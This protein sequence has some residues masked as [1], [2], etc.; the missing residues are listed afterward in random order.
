MEEL[1]SIV[2]PVRNR[3][4][5]VERTLESIDRQ[6]VQPKAII[7]VDNDSTD[8]TIAVLKHWA[9]GRDNVEVI[10]E[11]KPGAA[12]ARNA[13]LARVQT[14][15]V[16]FFDSDDLMPRRHVEEVGAGLRAAG[17]PAIAEFASM[18]INPDRHKKLAPLRTGNPLTNHIFHST[19]ATQRYVAST[20]LVRRV[21]GWNEQLLGWDDLE[22]GVRLLAA[23]SNPA[24]IEL[25]E[26]VEVYTHSDSITGADF[27]SKAGQWERALDWCEKALEGDRYHQRL[28]NYRRAILAGFYRREGCPELARGLA[29]GAW[30]SMIAAYVAR[31][32]RGV[33]KFAIVEKFT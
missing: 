17:M 6:S 27:S 31:G 20:E 5:L 8:S 30:M 19:L 29:R 3:A 9:A 24:Q 33:A 2:I 21:G 23:Y 7:L 26:P 18:F 32:G 4:H 13:G 22:L 10:S 12:C 15:Y 1:I 25:T 11:R 16:M 14:P 28:I